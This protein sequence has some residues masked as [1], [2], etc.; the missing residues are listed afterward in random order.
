MPSFL[1]G[2]ARNQ[3]R[4]WCFLANHF[5][6]WAIFPAPIIFCFN[7]CR[8]NQV[9]LIVFPWWLRML[10]IFSYISYIIFICICSFGIVWLVP[11][12]YLF[13]NCFFFLLNFWWSLQFL[14]INPLSDVWLARTFSHFIGCLLTLQMVFFTVINLTWLN[15]LEFLS[16]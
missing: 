2:Q 6:N 14:D 8:S 16:L 7:V 12:V 10:S 13:I 9:H 4:S 3:T 5:T 11:F 1:H 15:L